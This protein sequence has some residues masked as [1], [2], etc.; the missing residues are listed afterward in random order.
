MQPDQKTEEKIDQSL[1]NYPLRR[2]N[3]LYIT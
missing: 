3:L 1:E 2:G